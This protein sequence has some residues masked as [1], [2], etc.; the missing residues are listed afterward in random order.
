[1]GPGIHTRTHAHPPRRS[2]PQLS[3]SIM[4]VGYSS[5]V[6][7]ILTSFAYRNYRIGGHL[8]EH[9]SNPTLYQHFD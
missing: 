3:G 5:P 1:M 8:A 4:P 9:P 6:Q 2:R 7:R